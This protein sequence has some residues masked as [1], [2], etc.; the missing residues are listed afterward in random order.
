MEDDKRLYP[1]RFI[2]VDENPA[3]DV[4]LADLGYQDSLV[5]DGWLAANSISEIMD[6]Y[7]DRVVGEH[8]FEYYGRQFPVLVKYLTGTERTALMVSPDD[9]TAGQRFDF[10][11]K[12]KLWYIVSARPGGKI[13]MGFNRDVGA[14]EFYMSCRHGEAESLLNIIEPKAGEHYFIRPGLVHAAFEGVVIAE[15]AES[16]PL[17]FRIYNWGREI[18]GDEFDEAL[19]LDAAFDFIDYGKYCHCS[20]PECEG[21]GGTCHCHGCGE[22]AQGIIAGCD[23]FSVSEIRLDAPLH[24]NSEMMDSFVVY[25]CLNGAAS[26]QTK[27][28]DCTSVCTLAPRD[29]V[30]IPAEVTDYILTPA[31]PR[32]LLLEISSGTMEDIDPYTGET[33]GTDSGAEEDN[34]EN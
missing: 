29:T 13:C 19:N 11:G 24:R 3:E 21:E 20:G 23:E 18:E 6:M 4:R 33:G 28:G 7:V 15:V 1:L 14:E 34:Y 9:E 5:K 31:A 32:T 8:A 16:S 2:P 30:L 10:L 17:D 12:A 27:D 25:T 22:D 26:V